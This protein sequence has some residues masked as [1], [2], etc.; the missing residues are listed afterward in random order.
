[1]QLQAAELVNL[2]GRGLDHL[3]GSSVYR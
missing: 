3:N 2:T 1:V